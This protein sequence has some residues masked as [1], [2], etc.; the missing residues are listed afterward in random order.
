MVGAAQ[1]AIEQMNGFPWS[2]FWHNLQFGLA[3]LNRYAHQLRDVE[4]EG[5]SARNDNESTATLSRRV[6]RAPAG[7][8]D[9]TQPR[10][11]PFRTHRMQL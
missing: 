1:L 2:F 6:R 9:F 3:T 7:T 5:H 8:G 4:I 10:T 11:L